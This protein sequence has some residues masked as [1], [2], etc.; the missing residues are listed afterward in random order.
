ML[1][2]LALTHPCAEIV[3]WCSGAYL[4]RRGHP[5][6]QCPRC[7]EALGTP[8]TRAEEAHRRV[9]LAHRRLALTAD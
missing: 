2:E 6:T 5:I 1:T 3:Y 7:R 4:D 9:H 8:W